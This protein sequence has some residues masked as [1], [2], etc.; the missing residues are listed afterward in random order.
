MERQKRIA[1]S[2]LFVCFAVI[3]CVNESPVK[4]TTILYI[5]SIVALTS[6]YGIG[7]AIC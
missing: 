7:V 5:D 4:K 1:L 3:I 6:I 2:L